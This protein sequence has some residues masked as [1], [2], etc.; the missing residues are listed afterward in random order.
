MPAD[1]HQGSCVWCV[2]SLLTFVVLELKVRLIQMSLLY[3]V[4]GQYAPAPTQT[5]VS[6][7]D[8]GSIQSLSC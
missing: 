4:W 7:S 1:V 6:K 3:S 2:R 5:C 8:S